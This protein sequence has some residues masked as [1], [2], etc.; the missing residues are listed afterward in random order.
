[1]IRVS[2]R[3]DNY[4]MEVCKIDF[5]SNVHESLKDYCIIRDI[6]RMCLIA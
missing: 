6:K 5:N 3:R 1:M 4:I 2:T